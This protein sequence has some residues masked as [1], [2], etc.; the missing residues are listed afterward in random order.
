MCRSGSDSLSE[1]WDYLHVVRR[2]GIARGN[3]WESSWVG[4]ESGR[5]DLGIPEETGGSLR[6]K[7]CLR[8]KSCRRGK[9]ECAEE[10]ASA[11]EASCAG[12]IAG[13]MAIASV[14]VEIQTII[15][16]INCTARTASPT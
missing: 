16:I 10:L 4:L 13:A 1:K 14:G 7:L 15:I 6:E 5:T 11:E 2:S 12:E 3:Q 9:L 8:G